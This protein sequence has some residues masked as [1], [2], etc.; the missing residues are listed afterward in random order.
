MGWEFCSYTT[1]IDKVN[2][3]Q[4]FA[5][6]EV[7]LPTRLNNTLYIDENEA[8]NALCDKLDKRGC[9]YATFI[10]FESGGSTLR[11][12]RSNHASMGA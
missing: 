11:R 5:G 2:E 9:M 12:E 7:G 8:S 6:N 10:D 3:P 4:L 1:D